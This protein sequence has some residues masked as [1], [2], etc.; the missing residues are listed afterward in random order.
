[1]CFRISSTFF[2]FGES[3]FVGETDN[4]SQAN[5]GRWKNMHIK[6]TPSK[7]FDVVFVEACLSQD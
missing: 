2:F 4:T 6:A 5:F 1:M 3:P 7:V